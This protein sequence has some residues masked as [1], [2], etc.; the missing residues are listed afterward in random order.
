MSLA[1]IPLFVWVMVGWVTSPFF[2]FCFLKA[3]VL[4]T[5]TIL[6]CISMYTY[7]SIDVCVYNT[8]ELEGY[9]RIQEASRSAERRRK[10]VVVGDL[11]PLVA[12][13]PSIHE[14]GTTDV[15]KTMQ[16]LF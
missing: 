16:R 10:T 1:I 11:Q 13:L 6:S 5:C 12:A 9:K 4:C 14:A 8:S 15:E 2:S 3:S 7:Y